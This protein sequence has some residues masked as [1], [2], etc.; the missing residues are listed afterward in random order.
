M[1]SRPCDSAYSLW[2]VDRSETGHSCSICW[3]VVFSFVLMYSIF[4]QARSI[5]LDPKI[6]TL[7]LTSKLSELLKSLPPTCPG[8]SHI[9]CVRLTLLM[10]VSLFLFC[11]VE[12]PCVPLSLVPVPPPLQLLSLYTHWPISM[13]R[14][15]TY[16]HLLALLDYCWAHPRN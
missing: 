14:R 12:S 16:T 11:G 8:S 10:S 6:L 9:R 3:T 15:V 7:S 1:F 13:Y 5:L 2:F 4:N